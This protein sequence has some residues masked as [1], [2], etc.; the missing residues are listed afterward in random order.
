MKRILKIFNEPYEISDSDKTNN[1]IQSLNG[2]IEFDN[3]SFRYGEIF[4]GY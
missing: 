4:P 3:V 2:E 1:E